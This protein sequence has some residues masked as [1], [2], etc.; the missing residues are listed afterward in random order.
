MKDA[1]KKYYT[2]NKNEC[3]KK[4]KL[5]RQEHKLEISEQKKQYRQDNNI[6]MKQRDKDRYQ[7]RKDKLLKKHQ[8]E[9]GGIYQTCHKSRHFK[10]LIHLQWATGQA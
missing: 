3:I 8:C 2:E 10:S 7:N 6:E 9:C 1:S 4:N 5:Y